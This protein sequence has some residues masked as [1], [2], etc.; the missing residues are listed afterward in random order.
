MR[1]KVARVEKEEEEEPVVVE[2]LVAKEAKVVVDTV[3]TKMAMV[4]TRV[5]KL[6]LL[7]TTKMNAVN[8]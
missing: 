4:V 1:I 8:L 3:V 2:D 5:A 7:Y 6:D